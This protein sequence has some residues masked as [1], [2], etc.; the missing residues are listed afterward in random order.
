M[1]GIKLDTY[2][3][4]KDLNILVAILWSGGHL[5]QEELHRARELITQ[6]NHRVNRR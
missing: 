5:E 4:E 3:Q 6:L 1:F 2:Q